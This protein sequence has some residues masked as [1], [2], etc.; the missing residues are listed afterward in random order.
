MAAGAAPPGAEDQVAWEAELAAEEGRRGLVRRD[1]AW[2]SRHNGVFR[3][4][5]IKKWQAQVVHGGK[6]EHLGLFAIEEEAKA[7]YD[8]RCLELGLDPDKRQAS[9]FR[10]VSWRKAKGKWQVTHVHIS[11]DRKNEHLG[12]FEP[13]PAGEVGAALAYDAAA[14][15]VGRPKSARELRAG[16]CAT[17]AGG[18]AAAGGARVGAGA[19]PELVGWRRRRRWLG[20]AQ[21]DRC[22][23][24]YRGCR[25]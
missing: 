22:I 11:V 10:G 17:A 25:H 3:N 20:R 9:G 13:T 12:Y 2:S 19:R 18:G 23:A 8:T 15:K 14:R 7:R 21:V 1:N 5:A 4:T 6:Q 24:A 16:G